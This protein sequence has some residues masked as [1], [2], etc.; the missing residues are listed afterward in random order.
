MTSIQFSGFRTPYDENQAY[1][2]HVEYLKAKARTSKALQDAQMNDFLGIP[3]MMQ[4]PKTGAEILDNEQEVNKMVQSYLAEIFKDNPNLPYNPTTDTQ[5]SLQNKR[6]PSKFVY[7]QLDNNDKRTLI[8]HLPAIKS[9]LANFG[10][11]TPTGFLQ[12]LQNFKVAI[13]K[14]GGVR[15]FASVQGFDEIKALI[16]DLPAHADVANL[17]GS[18]RD[19]YR[20]L[21][22]DNIFSAVEQR[23]VQTTVEE[24]I[25]R[26]EIMDDFIPTVGDINRLQ[27]TLSDS[28]QQNSSKPEAQRILDQYKQLP[29]Q[30]EM[31]D[32][33]RFIHD[34]MQ[35]KMD[36]RDAIVILDKIGQVMGAVKA[37]DLQQTNSML[38]KISGDVERI[39]AMTE[40]QGALIDVRLKEGVSKKIYDEILAS[41]LKEFNDEIEAEN[42][43]IQLYNDGLKRRNE[44]IAKENFRR[45]KEY[46]E[47][48][49]EAETSNAQN[50]G[51]HGYLKIPVPTKPV[52]IPTELP[53]PLKNVLT[54]RNLPKAVFAEAQSQAQQM[55]TAQIIGSQ[56]AEEFSPFKPAEVQAIYNPDAYATTAPASQQGLGFKQHA[57]RHVRK[58][59]PRYATIGRGIS[60]KAEPKFIEFGKFCLSIPHL[61]NNVLKI[62]YAS[63]LADVSTFQTTHISDDFNDFLENFIDTQK[64]NTRLLEKLNMSEQKLFKKMINKSGLNVKYKMKDLDTEEERKDDERF[65]LVKSEFIAGNDSKHVKEELRRFLIKY[66][67]DGR[68]SKK[69]GNELLFQISM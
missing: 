33:E 21:R 5:L 1:T 47:K 34:S 67:L 36:K 44:D 49:S 37:S 69:D 4:V 53:R 14:T 28:I 68:I 50:K 38:Q 56:K 43:Q 58:V 13:R 32:L 55:A 10:V 17:Q 52:E 2:R 46:Q 20:D 19:F 29:T 59:Q 22:A 27:Q 3:P 23:Q 31:R 42:S 57:T 65:H 7:E 15:D 39:N 61:N 64:I 41:R 35:N 26:L 48:K 62:K 18:L 25:R 24:I 16:E 8:E 40:S 6:Y 45:L 30:T 63:T 11:I 66:M 54:L 9:E 60:I 51:K 12:Y